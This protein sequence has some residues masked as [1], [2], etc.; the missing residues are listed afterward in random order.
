MSCF[1]CSDNSFISEGANRYVAR[2]Y[3]MQHQVPINHFETPLVE[4]EE[5]PGKSSG[6][7]VRESLELLAQASC[8][9]AM[10]LNSCH[11]SV[12]IS[13]SLF[14]WSLFEATLF[15]GYVGQSPD[16]PFNF[17]HSSGNILTQRVLVLENVGYTDT[18]VPI[19]S[20]SIIQPQVLHYIWWSIFGREHGNL[21][22]TEQV[23]IGRQSHSFQPLGNS[24]L[25]SD[26]E[27]TEVLQLMIPGMC[28]L[29]QT[30]SDP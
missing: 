17:V 20:S 23:L 30:R 4:S 22:P 24:T 28:S 12:S 15:T 25:L 5:D 18:S 21:V 6:N 14:A 3:R 13:D 9:S 19:I 8:L 7:T 2:A 29:G 27:V 1:Q 11:R 26:L 16:I 10:V